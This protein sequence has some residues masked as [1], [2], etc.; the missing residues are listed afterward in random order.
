MRPETTAT[1]TGATPGAGAMPVQVTT[2]VAAAGATPAAAAGQ[3]PAPAAQPATG[4]AALGEAGKAALDRERDARQAAEDRAR[5]AEQELT[6]LREGSQSEQERALNAAKRE[7]GKERDLF[8]EAKFREVV[9]EGALR[10]AGIR[11]EKMLRLALL[12]PAFV[13]LK[14]DDTGAVQGVEAAIE[15]FKSDY[16]EAFGAAPAAGPGGSWGGAEGGTST[17]PVNPG[18][19]RVRRAYETNSTK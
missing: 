10:G 8:W 6:A 11:S 15:S 2:E 1:T 18:I 12:A 17:G 3:S 4:E 14:V 5:T 13:N 7:A 16:P 9:A 19:D